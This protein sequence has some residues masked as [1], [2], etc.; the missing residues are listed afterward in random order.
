MASGY[1]V[2]IKFTNT[3]DRKST[4]A[5]NAMNVLMYFVAVTQ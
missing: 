3:S 5:V 1:D 2:T 4:R